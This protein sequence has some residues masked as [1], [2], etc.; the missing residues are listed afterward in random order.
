MS[1][2]TTPVTTPETTPVTT[3][4]TTPETTPVTTWN[5]EFESLESQPWYSTLSEDH[6]ESLRSGYQN[7]ISNYERG[8]QRK[9][10]ELAE[11]RKSH[12]NEKRLLSETYREREQEI[13]RLLY[14]EGDPTQ[15]WQD[16]YKILEQQATEW[17]SKLDD[18]SK[19][20]NEQLVN[21]LIEDAEANLPEIFNDDKL[22]DRYESLIFQG[23]PRD[24]AAQMVRALVPKVEQASKLERALDV[25]T[26]PRT[27]NSSSLDSWEA[28][29]K[30]YLN[31]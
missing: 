7:K 23:V 2:E 15:E 18:I 13:Q 24:E 28:T 25:D 8:Y 26:V 21:A 12:E 16:K 6:R 5:G 14:G 19:T 17:K 3:P 31:S 22:W 27:V 4:V 9:Y 30:A 20:Q 1:V 29:K 10:Q 11:Q